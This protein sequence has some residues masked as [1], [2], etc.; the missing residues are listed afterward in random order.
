MGRFGKTFICCAKRGDSVYFKVAVVFAHT[1]PCDE[2]PAKRIKDEADRLNAAFTGFLIPA[3][4]RD[5]QFL[6]GT[7]GVLY[8]GKIFEVKC[9]L[10]ASAF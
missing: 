3:F 2:M 9:G 4:V 8:D 5:E 1:A 6:P 7:Y 10:D